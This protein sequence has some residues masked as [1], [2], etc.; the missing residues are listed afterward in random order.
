[1]DLGGPTCHGGSGSQLFDAAMPNC[2]VTGALAQPNIQQ[3]SCRQKLRLRQSPDAPDTIE[4]Q[5]R[6][7][8][9]G[10]HRLVPA[11]VRR[12]PRDD[13]RV[14]RI[15]GHGDAFG[16]RLLHTPSARASCRRP[17]RHAN[18][19]AA[20]ACGPQRRPLCG[21]TCMA[22]CPDA[23]T[24]CRTDL[25]RIHDPDLDGA[26]GGHIPRREVEPRETGVH[27]ARSD[28]RS[29]NR[30]PRTRQGQ[31]RPPL[32]PRLRRGLRHIRSH[33]QI[34]DAHR[35]RGAD[36]LLDA[37]H[38]IGDRPS[39]GDLCLEECSPPTSGHGSS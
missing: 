5:S 25:D 17:F 9:G 13:N 33:G 39:S 16:D 1:M 35:Q 2:R 10:I 6:L 12:R 31:S 37:G 27:P 24:A 34:A 14:E 36:H 7:L 11:D 3:S 4:S 22:V 29:D 26:A 28:R 23:H 30:A 18:G 19:A 8:D 21:A 38:P 15:P 32:R 20:P